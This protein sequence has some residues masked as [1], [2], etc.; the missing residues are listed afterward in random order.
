MRL[1]LFRRNPIEGLVIARSDVAEEAARKRSS[2]NMAWNNLR[3][4]N[5]SEP[6]V[7]SGSQGSSEKPEPSQVQ[8]PAALTSEPQAPADSVPEQPKPATQSAPEPTLAVSEKG[9]I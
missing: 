8:I 9:P 6:G 4:R 3:R 2:N 7:G 1:S 5:S